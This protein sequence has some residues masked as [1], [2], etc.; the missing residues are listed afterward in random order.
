MSQK[1]INKADLAIYISE[2]LRDVDNVNVE[3]R[4]IKAY[5]DNFEED[6]S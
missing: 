6:G 2:C 4:V 5:M 3:W 1:T